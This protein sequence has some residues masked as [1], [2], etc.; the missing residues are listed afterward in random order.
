MESGCLRFWRCLNINFSIVGFFLRVREPGSFCTDLRQV[1][2]DPRAGSA[3][4][5][6]AA[7]RRT[8]AP[9]R[10]RCTRAVPAP[11]TKQYS[12]RSDS[13]LR[14]HRDPHADGLAPVPPPPAPRRLTPGGAA[15]LDPYVLNLVAAAG[16][17]HDDAVQTRPKGLKRPDAGES[18][19]EPPLQRPRTDPLL[20]GA[21]LGGA[22]LGI[23]MTNIKL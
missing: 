9:L 21:G 6:R 5:A 4:G 20:P 18:L 14:N 1:Y 11:R 3:G 13:N 23:H 2:A 10:S 17:M 7:V 8:H 16:R 12:R 22:V 15:A 19:A